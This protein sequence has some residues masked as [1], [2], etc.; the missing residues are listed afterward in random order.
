MNAVSERL[1]WV[2]VCKGIGILL[3][4]YG[5]GLSGDSFRYII[6]AF[7]MPLFF[8]LSGVIFHH[9]KHEQFLPYLKKDIK[10][11]LLPYF[12]FAFISL[13]IW[14]LNRTPEYQTLHVL[15]KS[16]TGI[17]YGNAHNNALSFNVVLWF[18]PCLFVTKLAFWFVT[19]FIRRKK[20]LIPILGIASVLGYE[21]SNIFPKL[22]LPFGAEIVL[23]S[24]VFFGAGHLLNSLSDEKKL[25]I[26]KYAKQLFIISL[27]ICVATAM[28][29]FSTYHQQVDIRLNRF[30][31]FFFFYI[32]A[33]SGIISCMTLSILLNT[34]I[35]LKKLGKHSMILFVWHLIIF[36]YIT[37]FLRTFI[38]PQT[39]D[40]LRDYYLAPSYTIL[41][42]AIILTASLLLRRAHVSKEWVK[43]MGFTLITTFL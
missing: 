17:L 7:H 5:H 41:S 26:Q 35:L 6:Y 1:H 25:V 11:I 33:F 21:S 9:K 23:T 22:K 24:I 2:D 27:L 43:A 15:T 19:K 38:T 8:F 10:G 18:L 14:F 29:S 30:H 34:N 32:A 3:V 36:S 12:L 31:N 28:L 40:Q 20:L 39:I 4:I 13:G 16:I 37:K 42:L